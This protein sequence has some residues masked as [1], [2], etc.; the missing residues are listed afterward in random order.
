MDNMKGLASQ[1]QM[2]KHIKAHGK[3]NA[4]LLVLNGQNGRFGA[5]SHDNLETLSQAFPGFWDNVILILNFM[6]QD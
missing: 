5:S 3:V 2:I 4:F 1:E 6:Q